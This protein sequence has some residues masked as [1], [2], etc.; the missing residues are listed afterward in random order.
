[1]SVSNR[2][3]C[4]CTLVPIYQVT[5]RRSDDNLSITATLI[6]ESF[7]PAFP[8]ICTSPAFSLGPSLPLPEF[9]HFLSSFAPFHY[10]QVLAFPLLSS[11]LHLSFFVF[12]SFSFSPFRFSITISTH[13]LSSE[14]YQY[15]YINYYTHQIFAV[16]D[17]DEQVFVLLL[18]INVI[19]L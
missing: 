16:I 13:F 7:F 19:F 8:S 14:E 15:T 2:T 17:M 11:S 5:Q 4:W 10:A 1:M 18:I 12:C 3:G 6:S 9:F